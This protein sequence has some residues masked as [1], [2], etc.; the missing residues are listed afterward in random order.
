MQ[1]SYG[2]VIGGGVAGVTSLPGGWRA[3]SVQGACLGLG[4]AVF[5]QMLIKPMVITKME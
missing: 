3:G 4:L 2:G 1:L 5:A